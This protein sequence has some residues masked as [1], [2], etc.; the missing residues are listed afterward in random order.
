MSGEPLTNAGFPS[1]VPAP[2]ALPV[3]G[4]SPVP[5]SCCCYFHIF[6][7]ELV[8]ITGRRAVS[9]GTSCSAIVGRRRSC[10]HRHVK[11]TPARTRGFWRRAP[12]LRVEAAGAPSTE[13]VSV[14]KQREVGGR[15]PRCPDQRPQKPRG[16]GRPCRWPGR[17]ADAGEVHFR[18]QNP[19]FVDSQHPG[20]LRVRADARRAAP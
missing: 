7:P 6:C 17:I 13:P 18:H 10:D 20:R 3:S 19:A 9:I 12:G 8:T 11:H 14:S 1:G 15:R 16:R 4:R 5:L 2:P